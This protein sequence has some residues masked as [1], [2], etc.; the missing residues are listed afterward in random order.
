MERLT[1]TRYIKL[2]VNVRRLSIVDQRND[3]KREAG[4]FQGAYGIY[5]KSLPEKH[6]K[7]RR[8]SR[9]RSMHLCK[10][11]ILP[12]VIIAAF[13]RSFASYVK[14]IPARNERPGSDGEE[15]KSITTNYQ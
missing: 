5:L 2:P 7:A 1:L 10:L 3:R 8:Q 11:A 13:T 4:V 6:A 14:L 15:A 12:G 9:P